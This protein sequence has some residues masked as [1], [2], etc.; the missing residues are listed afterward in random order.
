MPSV[1]PIQATVDDNRDIQQFSDAELTAIAEERPDGGTSTETAGKRKV[2]D[3]GETLD[4][5]GARIPNGFIRSTVFWRWKDERG[6]SGL[7]EGSITAKVSYPNVDCPV[8]I[9]CYRVIELSLRVDVGFDP[10]N[11]KDRAA[12][13][14]VAMGHYRTRAP[15][16]KSPIR[17]LRRHAQEVSLV[18]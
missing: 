3:T 1:F 12:L 8:G 18:L 4:T 9:I 2:V 10:E 6:H 7:G 16:A 15:A 14:N 11:D 13:Q 5:A 17:S